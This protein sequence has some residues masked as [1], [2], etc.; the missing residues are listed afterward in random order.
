[1]T[2][3]TWKPVAADTRYEVSDKGN[4]RSTARGAPRALRRGLSSNGYWTV[5]LG[6]GRTRT[7]HS[8]VAEAFLGPCPAGMEV[9]HKDGIRTNAAAYN[10][11]YG[12]RRDNILDAVAHGTWNSDA[13]LAHLA[14]CVAKYRWGRQ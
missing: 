6:R 4:V 14:V 10:L 11:C 12:T 5:C 13:R 2:P 9:R 8:L 1:M 3:E 7:V